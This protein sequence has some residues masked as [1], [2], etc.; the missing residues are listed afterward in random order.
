[1]QS[2]LVDHMEE[3][4]ITLTKAGMMTLSTLGISDEIDHDRLP[5]PPATPNC[6]MLPGTAL[7]SLNGY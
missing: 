2:H 6:V 1:M 5:T 7:D 3:I 4:N